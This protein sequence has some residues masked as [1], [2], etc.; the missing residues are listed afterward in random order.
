MKS[1]V[2]DEMQYIHHEKF[3]EELYNWR[4]D[5]QEKSNLVDEP[6]ARVSLNGFRLYLKSLLGELFK[7]P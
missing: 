2:G 4:T 6:S 1:V 5:P 3:G 7:I